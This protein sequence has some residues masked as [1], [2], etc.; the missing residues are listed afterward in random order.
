MDP[1]LQHSSSTT[2]SQL[3]SQAAMHL[4]T[5][6]QCISNST[7]NTRQT[8]QTRQTRLHYISCGKAI[9]TALLP[10]VLMSFLVLVFFFFFVN[11]LLFANCTDT[12][13]LLEA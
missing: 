9:Y 4:Q 11:P 10:V 5:V 13:K 12:V 3:N 1:A 2:L 6:Q 7:L 8:P